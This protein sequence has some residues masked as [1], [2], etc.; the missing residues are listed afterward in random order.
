MLTVSRTF[1][2]I[3]FV[4]VTACCFSA[5]SCFTMKYSTSGA[6]I[7]P[8]AKTVSVQYFENQ[9]R[10]QE[11]GLN[12]KVTDDLKDYIQANTSLLLINGTGDVDFEGA[13]T[14]FDI[15]PTAI[16]SGDQAAKNRFTITIKVKFTCEVKPELDFESSFSRYEDYDPSQMEFEQASVAF[17]DDILKLL[18]EDIFNKAFVNW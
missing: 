13:I 8:E 10:F 11:A 14:G 12:Q 2:M 17:T 9:A 3:V 18:I 1:R 16:V 6:S 7:P 5:G 4:L 15:K